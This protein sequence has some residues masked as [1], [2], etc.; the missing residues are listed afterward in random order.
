MSSLSSVV[1]RRSKAAGVVILLMA[2]VASLMPSA[3]P[4]SAGSTFSDDNNSPHEAAIEYIASKGV[5]QGCNPPAN[6]KFCPDRVLTRGEMATFI[7]RAFDLKTAK[8]DKFSDDNGSPH[9]SAIN[10]LAKADVSEGCNPPDNS[11]F[12][13]QDKVTR[14]Q[15]AAFLNR[16][17]ELSP[18]GDF[19]SDD[20]NSVFEN[21][22]NAIA[23]V[24]ISRG[25]NPPANTEYCPDRT[26]TRAE[27]ASFLTRAME[28]K[29]T[30]VTTTTTPAPRTTTTRPD[31]DLP[32]APQPP[33]GG[34]CEG[35][36]IAA[37]ANPSG[38]V[39]IKPG[40]SIQSAVNSNPDG[41]VFVI[42]A[43]VHRNQTV[44]PKHRNQ[45][46]GQ[47]G[48][49]LDGGGSTEYA[50]G[51]PGD[52]VVIEGLEIRNYNSDV[53]EGVIRSVNSS[54]D[55][56]VRSNNIHDNKGQGITF[57]GG[58]KVIGN[59]LHH[60]EQYGIGGSGKNVLIERNEIAYNNPGKTISPYWGAGGTKFNNTTDLVVR[61]NCSHDNE[62]PGLWTDGHNVNTLYEGNFVY[63]N[64]HAGI[65]HEV[66]CS[67][68]IRN[69]T[70]VG[71]GFGNKNWLAGA[72]IVVLNS[73]GVT[74]TGNVVRNNE[75]GIAGIQADRSSGTNGKNCTLL[76]KNLVVRDNT[77]EMDTGYSGI[78]AQGTNA[79]FDSWGNK[80][81]SNDYVLSK[82]GGDYFKWDGEVMNLS[83][84]K[85]A[86]QG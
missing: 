55:W 14:G 63:D 81:S 69:N 1:S 20:D 6:D 44:S 26:V 67:A 74:I 27:M 17:L 56:T 60:N 61:N 42:A 8:G 72:G 43:G 36:P 18:G 52:N 10:A 76:L 83:E 70:A 12:C 77:I 4:A 3:L 9:E 2:I 35:A 79:V 82:S 33:A 23:R 21:D 65:K 64:L 31:S 53:G 7:V 28:I 13:P 15:M 51:G 41:T 19:F 80:F 24:G 54:S 25:C 39:V 45:F 48:A 66:S 34:E 84:W 57:I 37:P 86:G 32:P 73:P 50:F 78:V 30:G 47:A 5:T 29:R 40:Q 16:V 58:W 38:D 49:I 22:I 11:K 85:A 59:Y 62:G 71:N 68:T 46:L 75:D